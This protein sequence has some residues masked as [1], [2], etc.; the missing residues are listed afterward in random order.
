MLVHYNP[1]L[2]QQVRYAQAFADASCD[3]TPNPDGDADIHIVQGPHYALNR[4][5]HHSRVLWLDRAYW[6][7]PDEVTLGWLQPDGTRKFARGTHKRDRPA[8]LPWKTR[9]ESCLVLADYRQNVDGIVSEAYKRFG[10]VSVRRHPVEEKHALSLETCLTLSDVCI[11][12]TSTA[13]IDAIVLG[14]PVICT[15]PSSSVADVSVRGLG[16]DLYRGGREPWLHDLS[17]RQW[18]IDEIR[19]GSAL[20]ALL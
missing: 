20:R 2:K 16:D 11:G 14:V 1:T 13:L 17:W 12:N 19:D 3:I 15:D 8:T 4:W 9:E 5:R 18:G 10:H 6:G 7:D